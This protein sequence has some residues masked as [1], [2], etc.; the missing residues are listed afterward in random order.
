MQQRFP[1]AA[2]PRLALTAMAMTAGLLPAHGE[3][4]SPWFA[5]THSQ[6][7]LIAGS[8]T[9]RQPALRAGLDLKL[10][11]G[12]KTYWRYPGD[13][14]VPPRFDFTASSN[15]KAVHVLWPAPRRMADG[16]GQSIGYQN[17]V[18]LPLRVVP[19]DPA[20]PVQL[21]LKLSY[22][23]CEKLCVPAEATTQLTLLAAA[24]PQDAALTAAEA[25]VPKPAKLGSAG[26]VAIRAVRRDDTGSRPRIVVDV[27]APKDVPVDL[28]AEGPT[29]A[30]A[31]PLPEPRGAPAPEL[32]QFSF[33]LDG[34]PAGAQPHGAELTFTLVA[35]AEAIEV[36]TRLD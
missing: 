21:H 5:D 11:P 35:G 22:A 25:R 24:S 36:K 23:V 20:R 32:K 14:G 10:A 9:A 13:S 2:L 16:G 3:D 29:P 27:A 8:N 18:I 12:W 19:A 33:E 30:W 31:L 26:A 28:F 6:V 7:R 34:L 15:V 1:S 17:R 4:A